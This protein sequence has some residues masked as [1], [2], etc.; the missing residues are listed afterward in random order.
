MLML[1]GSVNPRSSRSCHVPFVMV[2][3]IKG[4]R[5]KYADRVMGRI[6]T[7]ISLIASGLVMLLP[8]HGAPGG[9]TASR[10][11]PFP[12][13]IS[14]NGSNFEVHSNRQ[15]SAK[16]L[17]VNFTTNETNALVW[18]AN[19]ARGVQTV[20]L[21]RKLT[22]PGPGAEGQFAI[23]PFFGNAWGN[24]PPLQAWDLVVNGKVIASGRFKFTGS[25]T[26]DIKLAR[27]KM[28]A[29]RF[30]ANDVEVRIRKGRSPASVPRCN[31]TVDNRLS[32]QF[33]LRGTF[34]ADL[35]LIDAPPPKQYKRAA[36]TLNQIVNLTLR[37]QGPSGVLRGDFS[38]DICCPSAFHVLS[39]AANAV[40]GIQPLAPPFTSCNVDETRKPTYRVTCVLESFKAKDR[41]ILTIGF[42]TGF[43][44][45]NFSEASTTLSWKLA[46]Q[47]SG[48]PNYE[49]NLRSVQF[50]WCGTAA[51]SDGCKS[52]T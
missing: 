39:L 10:A 21:H 32:V 25:R 22:L 43:A 16:E 45:V 38:V 50:V 31:S 18:A 37:N 33:T 9:S 41:A 34:V 27:A 29:F 7:A 14:G 4:G 19:C 48:D 6:V 52:A 2:A 44:N 51:T 17:Q 5:A 13:Y 42:Q 24:K 8:A 28:A 40:P 46:S 12:P 15:F 20:H 11:A 49:N 3:S 36:E 23:T 26:A 30:G 47:A 35:A 1:P